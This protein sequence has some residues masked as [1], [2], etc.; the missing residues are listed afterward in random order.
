MVHDV[1]QAILSPAVQEEMER[2]EK[3]WFGDP[4]ACQSKGSSVSSSS[5]G[6]SSFG[7]LFLVSGTVSGLVLLIQLSILVYQEHSKLWDASLHKWFQCLDFI[8]GAKDWRLPFFNGRRMHSR[9]GDG[10]NQPHGA[11]T[12]ASAMHDFTSE[13]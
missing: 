12:E 9:N 10:V 6:I 1:S 13:L 5:L 4:G 11:T 3:K 7:G 2:I 8:V